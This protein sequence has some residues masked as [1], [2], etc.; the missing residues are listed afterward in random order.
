MLAFRPGAEPHVTC[1]HVV[2]GGRFIT[3]PLRWLGLVLMIILFFVMAPWC[4]CLQL[5]LP[6]DK[7]VTTKWYSVKSNVRPLCEQHD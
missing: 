2:F 6:N 5:E 3:R 4:L 1:V 7:V